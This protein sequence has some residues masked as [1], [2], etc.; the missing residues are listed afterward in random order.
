MSISQDN[1][2]NVKFQSER[3]KWRKRKKFNGR[4]KKEKNYNNNNNDE[5]DDKKK[6]P[7][8]KCVV[9][10]YSVIERAV[11]GFAVDFDIIFSVFS[12]VRMLFVNAQWLIIFILTIHIVCSE[13]AFNS[14]ENQKEEKEENGE[15]ITF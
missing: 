7:K 3:K 10:G 15:E 2:Q 14:T 6:P 11:V 9:N 8:K 4:K 1:N 13:C 5:N 12:W